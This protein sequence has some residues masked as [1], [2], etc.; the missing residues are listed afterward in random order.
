[1]AVTIS[2]AGALLGC[3]APGATPAADR[4]GGA[5]APT[6]LTLITGESD[7]SEVQPFA[8]AVERLTGGSLAIEVKT[9]WRDG[10][11][12]YETGII[13]DVI[14]GK[15]DLGV[16]GVRAFDAE[17]IGVTAFQGFLAPFLITS[18]ELQ[19]R[20]LGGAAADE[21]LA[22]LEPVGL[23]GIGLDPGA[24][25]RP[26]GISRALL[27]P[28]DYKGAKFGAREGRVT[29]ATLEALGGTATTFVPGQAAG[30]D[31]M[32]AHIAL[33]AGEGYDEGAASLASD[34]VL[35]PRVSVL[36]VN[37]AAFDRLSPEQQAA[38][39]QAATEARAVRLTEI[40][41][42]EDE[43]LTKLCRRG[44]HLTAAGASAIDELRQAVA[45]VYDA[46]AQDPLAAAVMEDARRLAATTTG[47]PPAIECAE[48]PASPTASSAAPPSPLEGAWEACVTWE[49]MLAA[50]AD[51]GE[52][53]RGNVGCQVLRFEGDRFWNYRPGSEPGSHG[54]GFDADGTF[55][56]DEA[57]QSITFDAENGERFVYTWS[58]FDD[59]LSFKKV[60]FGPTNLVVKPFTRTD[61]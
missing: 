7:P 35:W 25:R 54:A 12:N 13:G 20:V 1:M 42:E 28:S 47:Q 43:G 4:A 48:A 17:P 51:A 50:G 41:W 53:N 10:E 57:A 55:E 46:I 8:D 52:N 29:A 61:D 27:R 15:A 11:A 2:L 21:T 26:L 30:L 60:S 3:Q 9:N 32:E 24:L 23:K 39:R 33:I 36:F 34:V 19:E 14:E 56:I 6:K 58:L 40:G 5:P 18:S 31:G 16:T 37:A 22:A 59:T 38:M 49:E 45:P 44:I